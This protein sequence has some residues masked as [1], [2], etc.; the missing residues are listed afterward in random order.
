M[1]SSRRIQ[2]LRIVLKL[3]SDYTFICINENIGTLMDL[4]RIHLDERDNASMKDKN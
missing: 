1:S 3:L 4:S 2:E